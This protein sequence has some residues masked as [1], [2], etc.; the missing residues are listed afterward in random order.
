MHR[1]LFLLCLL[2]Y[3]TSCSKK[4][5]FLTN[6]A[7]EKDTAST[8]SPELLAEVSGVTVANKEI[9]EDSYLEQF[10]LLDEDKWI[11]QNFLRAL[12]RTRSYDSAVR[13]NGA[14]ILQFTRYSDGSK[15]F[16]K[17]SFHTLMLSVD[18]HECRASIVA[19]TGGAAQNVYVSVLRGFNDCGIDYVETEIFS[20]EDA[21]AEW[22][23]VNF[24]RR[25]ADEDEADESIFRGEFDHVG[26]GLAEL[27]N[28][29]VVAGTYADKANA[30][31][32]FEKKRSSRDVE[33]GCSEY[34]Y[35]FKCVW[36][37]TVYSY[38]LNVN[39]DNQLIMTMLNGNTVEHQYA[40]TSDQKNLYLS[41]LKT[42]EKLVLK[43]IPR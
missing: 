26:L 25:T 9:G 21:D 32:Q 43:R 19:F 39:K 30:S 2:F 18:E 38:T 16:E 7:S 24:M 11:D 5:E 6:V 12:E 36:A 35:T 34:H 3:Y 14:P 22:I 27:L 15:T 29:Y 40:I 28:I 17:H 1:A 42:S 20:P 33:E 31:I 4:S 8:N 41:D 37:G 10:K 13:V 23:T